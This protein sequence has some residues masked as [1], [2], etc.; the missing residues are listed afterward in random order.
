MKTITVE[1]N[2]EGEVIIETTGFKGDACRKATEEVEK[3]LGK[4]TKRTIKPEMY[5][6]EVKA[7]QYVGGNP[8]NAYPKGRW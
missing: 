1:I 5:Q 2:N 4:V 6:A 7:G 3:A 8:M